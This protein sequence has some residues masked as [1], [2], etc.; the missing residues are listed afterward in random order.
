M[1]VFEPKQ[2]RM[3]ITTE[4][5]PCASWRV[6][7]PKDACR[8]LGWKPGDTVKVE[9]AGNGMLITKMPDQPARMEV[10]NA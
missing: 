8:F 5:N 9:V 7:L 4:K 2:S 3:R 6:V 10:D 1:S